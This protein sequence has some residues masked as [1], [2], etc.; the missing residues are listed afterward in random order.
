MLK[1]HNILWDNVQV[2]LPQKLFAE[3]GIEKQT[4]CEGYRVVLF[5]EDTSTPLWIEDC[6]FLHLI[7]AVFRKRIRNVEPIE[8]KKRLRRFMKYS[9]LRN[10]LLKF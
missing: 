6:R 7:C 8:V 4:A 10:L 2:P 9:N 1:S 5:G 3:D